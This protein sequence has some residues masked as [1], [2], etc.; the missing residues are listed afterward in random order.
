[1]G[2]QQL[3]GKVADYERQIENYELAHS[4]WLL[5]KEA[6]EEMLMRLREQLK[7]QQIMHSVIEAQRVCSALLIDCEI[8]GSSCIITGIVLALMVSLVLDFFYPT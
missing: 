2:A 3:Q 5:E 6:L 8:F 7:E 4:D 1:M